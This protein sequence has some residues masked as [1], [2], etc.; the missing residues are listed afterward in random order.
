MDTKSNGSRQ[1]GATAAI[2]SYVTV[3]PDRPVTIS[4]IAKETGVRY[5]TIPGACARIMTKFP[6]RLDR[7]GHGLYVWRSS[8]IVEQKPSK[9]EIAVGELMM[10]KILKIADDRLLVLGDGNNRVYTMKEIDW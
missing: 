6:G 1:S 3:N 9:D 10:V 5:Q 7:V 2:I 8:V 4:E